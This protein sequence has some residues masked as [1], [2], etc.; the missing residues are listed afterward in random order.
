[1]GLMDAVGHD[2]RV[3]VSFVPFMPLL[4]GLLSPKGDDFTADTEACMTR[5]YFWSWKD[6]HTSVKGRGRWFE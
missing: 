1:M 2:S 5:V 4:S 3:L 6:D